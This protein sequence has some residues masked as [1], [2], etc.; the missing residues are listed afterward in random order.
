MSSLI[1]KDYF[2]NTVGVFAQNAISP[3]LLIAVTRINGIYI[4]GI[5]SFAFSI[6]IIFWALGIWGGRTYQVSDVKNEFSHLSYIAVRLILAV[7]MLFGVVIFVLAN[8][9]DNLQSGVMISLVL[10]K[11]TES[12]A[13]VLYGILQVHGRLF[14]TGKSLL[15]K[16]VLGCTFFL[17][18]DIL[19]HNIFLSCIGIIVANILILIVF[20]LRAAQHVDGISIKRDMTVVHIKTAFY[21]IRKCAPISIVIFLAMFS[22]NI[23]R[24]F[25]DIYSRNQL[26]YFGIIA[27]PITLLALVITFILQPN[28][29]ELSR[30]LS[31]GKYDEFNK[32]VSRLLTVVSAIGLVILFVTALVGVEVLQ[33]VFGVDFSTYKVSLIVIVLGAIMNA[34]VTIYINILTIMRHFKSQLYTL[35]LTNLILVGVSAVVVKDYGLLGGV[36]LYAST[37]FIQGVILFVTYSVFLK[38]DSNL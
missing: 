25:I 34:I 9:Y 26:G 3:I 32:I 2:W 16:A 15:C 21:I 1:K 11:V 22:L 10:F 30:V 38:K 6:A 7:I 20:D 23:P 33:L 5:F 19:T 4:S 28:I 31:H 35:L 27:M 36:I 18:V 8:H 13:D 14:S 24:Y 17:A 12:I 37:N 29:V